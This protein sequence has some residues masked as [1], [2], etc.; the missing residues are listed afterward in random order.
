MAY[1]SAYSSKTI[2]MNAFSFQQRTALYRPRTPVLSVNKC[3][4]KFHFDDKKRWDAH[5]G[6]VV[7]HIPDPLSKIDIRFHQPNFVLHDDGMR[8]ER[9]FF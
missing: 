3:P 5:D 7:R 2:D 8:P 9:P 6:R 1:S 4:H